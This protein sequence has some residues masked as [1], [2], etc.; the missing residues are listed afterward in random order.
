MK[1]YVLATI[2]AFQ[3][4]GTLIAM[5]ENDWYKKVLQTTGDSEAIDEQIVN[6]TLTPFGD[7]VKSQLTDKEFDEI[8]PK[9]TNFSIN[10]NKTLELKR[11]SD[12]KKNKHSYAK[13]IVADLYIISKKKPKGTIH[14]ARYKSDIA[15]IKEFALSLRADYVKQHIENQKEKTEITKEHNEWISKRLEIGLKKIKFLHKQ[16]MSTPNN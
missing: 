14:Q 11:I 16:I 13:N 2:L 4:F 7:L 9:I 8:F 10:R 6:G 3:S 5:E 1:H 15:A 12:F